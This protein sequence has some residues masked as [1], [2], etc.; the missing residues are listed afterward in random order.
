MRYKILNLTL[1]N[2]ILGKIVAG[3]I[4]LEQKYD[5]KWIGMDTEFRDHLF[6]LI[7][8]LL[9][10]E[11]LIPKK[12]NGEFV[13][14]A[15]FLAYIL[16][17]FQLFQTDRMPHA[18]SIYES[19]IE[20]QMNILV[21]NCFSDYNE[22]IF[23]HQSIITDIELIPIL[24]EMS[25]NQSLLKFK[26]SRK[27]GNQDHELKFRKILENKID[28]I[29]SEWENQTK[30]SIEKIKNE[31]EN[32]RL[33]VEEK[34]KL[35]QE[36]FDSE[37]KAFERLQELNKIKYENDL[38]DQKHEQE[39]KIAEERWEAEKERLKRVMAEKARDDAIAK[40]I[41]AEK[42]RGQWANRYHESP[43]GKLCRIM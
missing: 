27:M 18:H 1:L 28:Q 9:K 20:Q 40:Q 10:P 15:E 29:F 24:H 21:N 3:G 25:K 37:K 14:G 38:K 31:M 13:K 42:E 39:K 32:A 22:T 30:E 34:L 6:A 36:Y 19:T 33:A 2:T 12:I 17:Y 23:K 11:R 26:E 8:H 43:F 5:G 41:E 35:Q 16:Q 4:K 7:E